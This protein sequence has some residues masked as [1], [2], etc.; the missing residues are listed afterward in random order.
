MKVNSTIYKGIEYV[1]IDTLPLEQK[2]RLLKT[3]NRDLLI[4]ILIDGRLV[5][6][7]LQ[8]KDYEIWFEN[9]YKAET[10]P[11]NPKKSKP[12]KAGESI[13]H[14]GALKRSNFDV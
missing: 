7:C 2:E 4:K 13:V 11:I 3:I 5:G 1:Q 14:I 6:N 9:I 8:F 10:K 12:E